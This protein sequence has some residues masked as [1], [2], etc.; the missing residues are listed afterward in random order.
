M[1]VSYEGSDV[2]A[3]KRTAKKVGSTN[4]RP[5]PYWR[6]LK[7]KKAIAKKAEL[8]VEDAA[9]ELAHTV[10]G[11]EVMARN[12]WP[13]KPFP[14]PN[15]THGLWRVWCAACRCPMR[16]QQHL[17]SKPNYCEDCS[18]KHISIGSPNFVQDDGIGSYRSNAVM[19]LDESK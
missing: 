16:V 14:L 6:E 19:A 2:M 5:I 11:G 10:E 8:A 13:K 4:P 12:G 17:T 9:A 7:A 1:D 3:K 15:S 18:P